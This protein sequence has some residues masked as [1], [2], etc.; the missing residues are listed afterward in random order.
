ML[1]R[2]AVIAHS[3]HWLINRAV[4]D[5]WD[6]GTHIECQSEIDSYDGLRQ[7][8][9]IMSKIGAMTDEP[10]PM[11]TAKAREDTIPIGTA[12]VALDASSLMCTGPSY[13]AIG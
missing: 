5:T 4:H 8:C 10:N 11:M 9:E 6:V 2:S 13:P 1:V 12:V 7:L 3:G